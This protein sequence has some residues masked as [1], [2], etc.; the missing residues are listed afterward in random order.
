VEIS[1]IAL[2]DGLLAFG[3]NGDLHRYRE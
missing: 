2:T 3:G 1:P